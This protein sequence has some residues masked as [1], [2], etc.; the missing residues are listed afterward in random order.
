MAVRITCINKSGG[1][2]DNPH[3]AVTHYGWK[4]EATN[5]SGKGDRQSMVNWVKN[6]GVAYVIDSYGN[7]VYCFV[8]RSAH[9][10]EFLQTQSDNRP[11]NN[12]LELPECM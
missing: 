12:L 7:K 2:H 10:T 1:Y 5:E 4:N 11:T 3:E 8:N 6:G 9:G